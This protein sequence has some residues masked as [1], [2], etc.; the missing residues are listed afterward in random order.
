MKP[1][2]KEMLKR[3]DK[4]TAMMY[5]KIYCSPT[6]TGSLDCLLMDYFGNVF[7]YFH[8][9]PNGEIDFQASIEPPINSKKY[10]KERIIDVARWEWFNLMDAN[11]TYQSATLRDLSGKKKK[12]LPVFD[13]GDKIK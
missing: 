3:K 1:M 5:K 11:K 10:K 2:D 12:E 13:L 7:S 9:S 6:P 8:V 4:H